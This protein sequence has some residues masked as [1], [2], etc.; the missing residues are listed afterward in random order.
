MP[1]AGKPNFVAGE[2]FLA[3]KKHEYPSGTSAAAKTS[4]H[5]HTTTTLNGSFRTAY[6][7]AHQHPQLCFGCDVWL[8]ACNNPNGT[9]LGQLLYVA[10]QLHGPAAVVWGS[11]PKLSCLPTKMVQLLQADDISI[12]LPN[13]LQYQRPAVLPLQATDGDLQRYHV[14]VDWGMSGRN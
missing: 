1:S 5:Q 8:E 14:L 12:C 3:L 10:W 2:G 13:L 6:K 4:A 9:Q 11:C 7:H